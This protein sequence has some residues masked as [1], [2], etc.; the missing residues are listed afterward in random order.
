MKNVN[1]FQ[2]I[3]YAANAAGSFDASG[4]D[5][6]LNAGLSVDNFVCVDNS[7]DNGFDNSVDNSVD[8]CFDDDSVDNSV[9]NSVNDGF[10]DSVN[11]GFDRAA[12]F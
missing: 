6:R 7:V 10:D 5:S 11:D 8:D 9:D 12:K 1:L 3:F 2:V 4:L